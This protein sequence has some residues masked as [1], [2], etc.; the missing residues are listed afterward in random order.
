[1][2]TILKIQCNTLCKD[3]WDDCS[4]CVTHLKNAMEQVGLKDRW[5]YRD[6]V[7]DKTFGMTERQLKEI[8]STAD[9]FINVSASTFMRDEG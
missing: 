7:T 8:C 9:T 1:M 6:V 2:C 4:G 3:K 5:A